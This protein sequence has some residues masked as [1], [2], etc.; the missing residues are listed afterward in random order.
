MTQPPQRKRRSRLLAGLTALLAV[1]LLVGAL[2]LYASAYTVDQGEQAVVVQFGD[3]VRTVTTPGLHL[4]QPFT[5]EVRRFSKKLLVWDGAPNEI[6]TASNQFIFVDTT[7]RWRIVD[8]LQF[9]KSVGDETGAQGRLD[10]ILDSTVREK[11]SETD[12]PNIVRDSNF[13][14]TR[15]DLVK[16][17]AVDPDQA[18]KEQVEELTKQVTVG[19]QKLTREILA[20]AKKKT[21]PLGIELVDLRIK[22]LNYRPDVQETVYERMISDQQRIAEKFRSEGKGEGRGD[23]GPDRPS[24]G[25]NPIRGRPRRR[26][27][28]RHG[29]RPGDEDLQRR[30]RVRPG[31]LRLLPHAGE[32]REDDGRGDHAGDRHGQ[33]VLPVPQEYR[34]PDHAAITAAPGPFRDLESSSRVRLARSEIRRGPGATG[35]VLPTR[36]GRHPGCGG[37]T[38]ICESPC[39]LS[40]APQRLSPSNFC[41][42]SRAG[43]LSPEP[44]SKENIA[45]NPVASFLP[46]DTR[47]QL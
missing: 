5:Q 41:D 7:A 24:T 39:R 34:P 18:P 29:R 32:L 8:P 14:V 23:P 45:A 47:Q 38:F 9:L 17:A 25:R 46:P 4:K 30:L 1:I 11:I 19:R 15:E 20:E 2:L 35:W 31:V 6:P 44:A 10:D 37:R 12:L 16:I 21:A 42:G 36:A 40:P 22:R 27:D 33:R 28:P 43:K 26:G 3:P 13:Q